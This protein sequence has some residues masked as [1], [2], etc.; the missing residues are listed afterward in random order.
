VRDEAGQE[1]VR[2]DQD[3]ENEVVVGDEVALFRKVRGV[4]AA[5]VRMGEG[6]LEE[7]ALLEG[8]RTYFELPKRM[9]VPEEEFHRWCREEGQ[10]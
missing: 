1:G 5:D 6:D 4:G 9:D 8:V 7:E 2:R 3:A 10:N